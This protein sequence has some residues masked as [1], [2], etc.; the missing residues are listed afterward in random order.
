MYAARY[1][2][3]FVWA[4]PDLYCQM[5]RHVCLHLNNELYLDLNDKLY[6]ELNREKLQKSFQ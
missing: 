1:V 3:S 2:S 5:R 4:Y 6:T